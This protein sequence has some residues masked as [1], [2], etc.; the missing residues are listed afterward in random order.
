M[1]WRRG[2]PSTHGRVHSRI[3][4]CQWYWHRWISLLA[5][6]ICRYRQ[7]HSHLRVLQAVQHLGLQVF[8]QGLEAVIS[9]AVAEDSAIDWL[10]AIST[11][12]ALAVDSVHQHRRGAG[13]NFLL[14]GTLQKRFHALQR[15]RQSSHDRV[16]ARLDKNTFHLLLK[17]PKCV[18]LRGDGRSNHHPFA[19]SPVFQHRRAFLRS[20]VPPVLPVL[21]LFGA[22]VAAVDVLAALSLALCGMVAQPG[23]EQCQQQQHHRGDEVGAG[24]DPDGFDAACKAKCVQHPD[25]TAGHRQPVKDAR[26]DSHADASFLFLRHT[27]LHQQGGDVDHDA[28]ATLEVR[29]GAFI[30]L[31]AQVVFR[32][33]GGPGSIADIHERGRGDGRSMLPHGVHSFF[34]MASARISFIRAR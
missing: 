7:S 23:K 9:P 4:G 25:G 11:V 30:E 34:S 17:P 15:V 28:P 16:F 32:K 31:F 8:V 20:C 12:Q 33:P 6:R 10:A 26:F 24:D 27:Q 18:I 29:N 13:Q 2:I 14:A 1:A 3:G 21:R 22:G 19:G 5:V